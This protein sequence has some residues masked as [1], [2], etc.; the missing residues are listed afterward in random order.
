MHRTSLQGMNDQNI[1]LTVNSTWGWAATPPVLNDF[2]RNFDWTTVDNVGQFNVYICDRDLVYLGHDFDPRA[3]VFK[4]YSG[5]VSV[6][7]W[8]DLISASNVDTGAVA[9]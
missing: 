4:L 5:H 1:V 3:H 6:T 7:H 2:Q 9:W 8:D